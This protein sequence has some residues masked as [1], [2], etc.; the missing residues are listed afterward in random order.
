ME[1]KALLCDYYVLA[2]A[3]LAATET[4]MRS[5]CHFGGG[6]YRRDLPIL[7]RSRLPEAFVHPEVMLRRCVRLVANTQPTR[8]STVG[9]VSTSRD[10]VG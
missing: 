5:V 2:P 7:E 1:R 9:S 8:S 6:A 3:A 10:V 4:A